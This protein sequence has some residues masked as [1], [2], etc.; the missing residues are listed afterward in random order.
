MKIVY[1]IPGCAVSGGIT[2]ICQHVNRLKNRGHDVYLV[3]ET[4]ESSIDWFPNQQV[5]VLKLDAYP[6]SVD[7]L[8]ATAWL[9][10]F[11]IAKLPARRKFY[12]VQSDETR[13]HADD[14]VW[15]HLTTISYSF[16]YRYITEA[17]WIQRW[18][19]ENFNQVASLVPNGL[20][21]DIFHECPPLAPRNGRPR[22][23]LEGAIALPY[24]GMK[25]AFEAVASLDAE[26]WCVSSLGRPEP[27]WR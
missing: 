25:E 1:L 6:D 20:D 18:L 27:S 16:H 9:T 14:S 23:L 8:V 21:A 4:L 22:I 10:S 3:T 12:F 26:I 13:F 5:P 7:I 19:A 17:R 11:R 15:Q 2:V 24:K